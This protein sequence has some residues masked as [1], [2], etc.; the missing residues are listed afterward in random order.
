MNDEREVVEGILRKQER[1]EKLTDREQLML[2]YSP[3]GTGISNRSAPPVVRRFPTS[4]EEG[5]AT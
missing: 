1:G 2:A 5:S 3:Y 4:R